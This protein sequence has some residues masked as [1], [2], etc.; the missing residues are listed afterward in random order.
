VVGLSQQI[1]LLPLGLLPTSPTSPSEVPLDALQVDL[2]AFVARLAVDFCLLDWQPA[3][4][5]E[6]RP[7]SLQAG[8]PLLA[9]APPPLQA[10]E[11]PPLQAVAP[12]PQAEPLQAAAPPPLQNHKTMPDTLLV[13]HPRK[14]H[15]QLLPRQA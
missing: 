8:P 6:F 5:N 10:V 4:S 12:P 14:D 1:G 11:P 9:A 15:V 7:Q 13:S 3:A 2:P